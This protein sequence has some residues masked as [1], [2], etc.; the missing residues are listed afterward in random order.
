MIHV[1]VRP[2]ISS[3]R[4]MMYLVLPPPGLGL[5]G[6]RFPKPVGQTVAFPT[7]KDCCRLCIYFRVMGPVHGG[8]GHVKTSSSATTPSEDDQGCV[9]MDLL[10][11]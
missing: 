2:G 6:H 11:R 5:E 1:T 10:R 7:N 3:G 8:G 9:A 4:L